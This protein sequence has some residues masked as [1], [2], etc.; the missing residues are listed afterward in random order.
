MWVQHQDHCYLFNTSFYNYS[1][2]NMA[3]AKSICQDM[4][5]SLLDLSMVD[6]SFCLKRFPTSRLL[7]FFFQM[8]SC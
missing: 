4:G 8:L 6:V 7:D 2:Y 3:K 5:Q 1:V